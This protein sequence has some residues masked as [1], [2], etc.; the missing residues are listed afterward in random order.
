MSSNL[1]LASVCMFLRGIDVFPEKF[2]EAKMVV[3]I[4][5][6]VILCVFFIEVCVIHVWSKLVVLVEFFV[7][8]ILM[9]SV[10]EEIGGNYLLGLCIFASATYFLK[11]SIKVTKNAKSVIATVRQL[12]LKL[13]KNLKI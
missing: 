2:H 4:V 10:Y 9:E 13:V 6:E 7:K 3:R 12:K 1:I 8:L 5:S 11:Y